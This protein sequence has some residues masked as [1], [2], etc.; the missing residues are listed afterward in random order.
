VAASEVELGMSHDTW[1]HRMI[2][3][4]V[5]RLATTSVTPNQLTT[6]RLLTAIAAALLLAT[7]DRGLSIIG[8]AIFLVSFFLDRAD[9]DLARLSGRSSPWGHRFDMFADYSANILVFLGIGLGL[10]ES[11]LGASAIALGAVAGSA[12]TLIFWLVR[13]VERA[14]GA[15][16]FPSAGGFD[17]DDAMI[18]IPLAIWLDGEMY[19]LMAAALGA[20]TFFGWSVWRFRKT[21]G[22]LS[23]ALRDNRASRNH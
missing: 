15:A 10:Q 14:E 19:I 18:V 8:G 5:R 17:P 11:A 3:P 16:V 6:L 21:L 22:Q 2:R 23:L 12:I 9:G 20:P 1:A 7:A 13:F 4:A